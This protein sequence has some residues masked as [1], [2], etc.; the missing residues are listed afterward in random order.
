MVT[1]GDGLDL[2]FSCSN[3]RA[4]SYYIEAILPLVVLGKDELVLV[5]KGMTNGP[6]D[7]SIDTINSCLLPQLSKFGVGGSL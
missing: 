2:E 3:K 5:L 4:L 7:V 6:D 1:N